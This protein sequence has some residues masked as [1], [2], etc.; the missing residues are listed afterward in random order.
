MALGG[1]RKAL[2]H[3]TPS[4]GFSLQSHHHWNLSLPQFLLTGFL[5][6]LPWTLIFYPCCS[7]VFLLFS[8][9]WLF[10]TLWTVAHQ[11]PLSMGF[12]SKNTGMGCHFLLQGFFLT[13]GVNLPLLHWQ[14]D[15]LLLSHQGSPV[16]SVS[17]LVWIAQHHHPIDSLSQHSF[18]HWRPWGIVL[19]PSHPQDCSFQLWHMFAWPCGYDS[20]D[21]FGMDFCKCAA[22]SISLPSPTPLNPPPTPYCMRQVSYCSLDVQYY[23]VC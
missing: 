22:P 14:A 20:D 15:S 2:P 11:A 13:Q 1:G 10:A 5:W 8:H 21:V 17:W 4:Q 19:K 3:L 7:H 23:P 16:P 12:P 9:V 18:H 6:S